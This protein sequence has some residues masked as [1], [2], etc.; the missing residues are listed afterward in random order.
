MIET[1]LQKHFPQ[2]SEP[3]LKAEI[4]SVA[5]LMN[6][7]AG[8]IIMDYGSYVR[9]VPLIIKGSI[10]V[11]HE[12]DDNERELLL[13]FL[14]D[15]ETCSMS[16]SCCLTQK[17]SM[18][19]TEALEDTTLLAIP[20]QYVDQWMGQYPSWK[21]FVMSSYDQRMQALVQVIDNIAFANLDERLM[22]YLWSRQSTQDTNVI[23]ATHKEIAADM[24][25]S[26]EAISR[27][28]KK[29]E[30]MGKVRLARNEVHLL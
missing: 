27:L 26:R 13:Y 9:L 21:N 7:Q 20:V 5:Q 1:L 22:D 30:Q 6:F 24:N 17:R 8:D 29:L 11:T 15:G 18:I 19:R 16:F 3:N 25:A 12:A 28:L 2:L 4:N 10:K 23:K 14:N